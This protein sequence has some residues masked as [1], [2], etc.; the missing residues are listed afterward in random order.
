MTVGDIVVTDVSDTHKRIR[1]IHR[2][3]AILEWYDGTGLVEEQV[4]VSHLEVISKKPTEEFNY[5]YLIHKK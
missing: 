3:I 5:F 1:E 2:S 4:H